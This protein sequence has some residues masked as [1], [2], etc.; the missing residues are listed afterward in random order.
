MASSVARPLD[1]TS[2]LPLWAQLEAELSR[3]VRAGAF[4]D[5]FPGEHDLRVAYEV[6]RHTVREA[7]RRLRESGLIDASRGRGTWVRKTP[8]EQPLGSLYSLFAEIQAR[9]M[10]STSTVLAQEVVRDASVAARFGVEADAPL[11]Y[12][13]RI[14]L[15]DGEPLA[16]DRIWMPADLAE[17]L[18]DADFS[19]G[20]LYD[21]LLNRCGILL[22]GGRELITAVA[23]TPQDRR[24]LELP[25]STGLLSVER[26]GCVRQRVV[27]HR[28]ARFRGDRFSVLAQWSPGGYQLAASSPVPTARRAARRPSVR[29]T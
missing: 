20:A 23:P 11:F 2:A 10:R 14:R 24:L 3:R 6:S 7:L 17:P 21:V 22:T 28:L 13:E 12:L 16:H 29:T 8:I 25:R 4:D 19:T 5:G 15:A 9:G 26:S 18:L 27:E 1:R